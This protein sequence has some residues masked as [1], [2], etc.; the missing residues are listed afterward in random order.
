MTHQVERH[1]AN[2]RRLSVRRDRCN[3]V[4]QRFWGVFRLTDR[5]LPNCRAAS[6]ASGYK[7]FPQWTYEAPIYEYWIE[8]PKNRIS[9][10]TPLERL[11]IYLEQIKAF[12]RHKLEN[13]EIG[14]MEFIILICACLA[15]NQIDFVDK[16]TA[17]FDYGKI[18]SFGINLQE[19]NMIDH[20]FPAKLVYSDH[21][22][23]GRSDGSVGSDSIHR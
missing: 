9:A 10:I 13:V 2:K 1:H 17:P 18:I 8:S 20:L 6:S 5:D 14:I 11:A 15:L 19:I 23:R 7:P 4:L 22:N 12:G 21:R 16:L 3:T